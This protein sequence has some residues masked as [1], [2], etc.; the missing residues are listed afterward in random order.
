MK[1]R[2]YA[3]SIPTAFTHAHPVRIIIIA[4]CYSDILCSHFIILFPTLL[5]IIENDQKQ[6][7]V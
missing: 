6:R 2:L 3:F 1:A 5:F 7:S 4:T